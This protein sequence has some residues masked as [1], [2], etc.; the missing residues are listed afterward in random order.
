MPHLMFIIFLYAIS[1]ELRITNYELRIYGN[2][3]VDHCDLLIRE[4]RGLLLNV[5]KKKSISI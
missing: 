4:I 5:S 1:I 2:R 3:I